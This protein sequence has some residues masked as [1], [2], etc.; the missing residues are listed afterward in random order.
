MRAT[1]PKEGHIP[2]ART[3]RPSA[4]RQLSVFSLLQ[5]AR[6]K[7]SARVSPTSEQDEARRKASDQMQKMSENADEVE[8]ME[9]EMSPQR[10][11]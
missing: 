9:T 1:V 7:L 3:W 11:W 5:K 4:R 6:K 2:A 10:V 8:D